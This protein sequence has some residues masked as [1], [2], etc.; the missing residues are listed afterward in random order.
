M[1]RLTL[2][3]IA[4][5]RIW[6]SVGSQAPLPPGLGLA[7]VSHHVPPF[8]AGRTSPG[9]EPL[10]Q[11]VCGAYVASDMIAPA[12]TEPSCRLC[13]IALDLEKG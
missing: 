1:P 7:F 2:A 6:S 13:R 9:G 3:E 5:P 11:A 12:E 4:R 8:T 10:E